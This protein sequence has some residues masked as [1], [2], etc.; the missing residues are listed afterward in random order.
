[1][2]TASLPAHQD[3]VFISLPQ[4]HP[5]I[6][7]IAHRK[8]IPET[9]SCASFP[10]VPYVIASPVVVTYPNWNAALAANRP[11]GEVT[12]RPSL[13]MFPPLRYSIFHGPRRE[14]SGIYSPDCCR[15]YQISFN[16]N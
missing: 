13:L 12:P 3:H 4:N 6:V 2:T 10:F 1:M 14:A 9:R 11:V 5:A 16:T 8:S 15:F 7:N